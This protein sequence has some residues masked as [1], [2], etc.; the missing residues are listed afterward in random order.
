M[1]LLDTVSTY[2]FIYLFR[3]WGGC[4]FFFPCGKLLQVACLQ[5]PL[6][7]S[8]PLS[9]VPESNDDK[10][11]S[12]LKVEK[13]GTVVVFVKRGHTKAAKQQNPNVGQL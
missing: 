4:F 11:D 9:F 8:R 5:S 12:M 13:P 10:G 2:L 6:F 1:G 7:L 3:W